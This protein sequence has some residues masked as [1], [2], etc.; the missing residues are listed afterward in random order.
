METLKTQLTEHLTTNNISQS[1]AAKAM[2][3]SGPTLSD[4][5]NDK[6]RG[7]NSRIESLVADYINRQVNTQAQTSQIKL[8]FDFVMTSNIEK[9]FKGADL[10]EA[11]GD[12][13]P[14]IG[15]SGVG[16]TTALKAI[17]EVKPSAIL[18]QVY[19]GIRKNRFL[20]KLCREA[21]IE[22]RGS[23]DDLFEAL[24]EKLKG[25]GRLIM[26]DEAEHF[27]IDAI[28]ALRR[29]ND[30]TG[31]GLLMA[32]L[33]MFYAQ[34]KEYQRQYG[35]VYNRMSIPIVLNLI[36]KDDTRRLIS[37][38]CPES[39]PVEIWHQ[40]AGGVARDLKFI[41]REAVRV[42]QL[43]G[44]PTGDTPTMTKIVNQVTK[45]LGRFKDHA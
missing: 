9:A 42:A 24:C 31:C 34:L 39:L 1:A 15:V 30:F 37:T 36:T 4:W 20:A 14:M 16:K 18:V 5:R 38:I 23:F 45:E 28:D 41:A 22:A 3:L 35:Y 11:Y 33:P 17:Q 21:D 8:D 27:P 44:V 7:D 29:I 6:Y 12:I 43:N 40:A 26:V 13:R 19:K 2:G 10:V 32:G 25:T